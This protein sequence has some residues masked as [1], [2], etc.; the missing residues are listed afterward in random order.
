MSNTGK[1]REA[2]IVAALNYAKRVGTRAG[3]HFSEPGNAVGIAARALIAE[4]QADEKYHSAAVHA[5]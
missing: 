1:L 4:V 5:D 3:F 2:L